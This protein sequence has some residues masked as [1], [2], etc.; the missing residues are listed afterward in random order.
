V[1]ALPDEDAVAAGVSPGAD[2]SSDE[3][4]VA[5]PSPVSATANSSPRLNIKT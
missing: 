5:I 2:A 3:H 1:T 4:A